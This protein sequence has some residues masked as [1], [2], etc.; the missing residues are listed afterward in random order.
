[1]N[2]PPEPFRYLQGYMGTKLQLVGLLEIKK[3]R[4]LQGYMGTSLLARFSKLTLPRLDTFKDIWERMIPIA[5]IFPPP[6][7]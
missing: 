2:V 3:F 5:S 4:Y 7:V 6:A 1:M